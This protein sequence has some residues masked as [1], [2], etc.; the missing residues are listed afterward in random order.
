MVNLAV[1]NTVAVT[2]ISKFIGTTTELTL[3][4]AVSK[5]ASSYSWEIPSTVTVVAGSDLTSN[6]IK[7]TFED[8]LASTASLYLGVK[9]VNGMGSSVT[10]NVATLSPATTSTA[11]LL[12]VSAIA[13]SIV[14]TVT[15]S[16]AICPTTASNVTYT[17]L[18]AAIRANTYNL[19]VPEG[20]TINGG[21]INTAT[22]PAT[23]SASFTVNYP[24]LFVISPSGSKTI[25]IQSENGF[26]VSTT[27]KILRLTNVGAVC[28]PR[29][30]NSST[31]NDFSVITYPNPFSTEFTIETSSKGAMS[32]S[33]YDMQGRL[34]EKTN[35]NKVGSKLAAGT[36]NVIVNQGTKVKTLRVIKR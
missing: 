7:V 8:V 12:K 29:F 13:P 34:V 32:V 17:I 10:V 16:F 3:T 27:N 4:A 22:I 15:G 31:E 20:C 14:G 25:T 21:S 1:S 9:A 5:L 18:T 19:T 2:D 35:T 23:A 11:R 28:A 36:Y 26:G 33:V 30:A 24:A 6:S